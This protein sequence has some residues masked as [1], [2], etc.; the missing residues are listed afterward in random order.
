VFLDTLPYNAHSTA[1]DALWAGLPVLTCPGGTFAGV[2]P[3]AAVRGGLPELIADSLSAYEEMALK[4]AR[5]AAMLAGSKRRSD[6]IATAVRCSIPAASP[7]LEAAYSR[8]GT[9]RRGRAPEGFT[10]AATDA[11]AS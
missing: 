7:P 10:V 2:L 5:D 4:L 11:S 9:P 6:R 3:Q 8:C 1:S